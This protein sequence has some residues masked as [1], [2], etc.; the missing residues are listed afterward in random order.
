MANRVE[1]FIPM[2]KI[3][4]QTHQ[5]KQ[6]H[7]INGKPQFYEPAELKVVRSKLTAHLA[8]HVPEKKYTGAIQVIVKWLF[9][10]TGKHQDGEYKVT[11]PDLD[12]ASKLLLDCCTKLRFWNDDAQISSLVSEKFWADTPGI[13]IAIENLEGR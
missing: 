1:F 10:I 13:Y 6:V 9:P 11:K 3:P 7:I 8:K 12:N 5:E 2:T 4:T